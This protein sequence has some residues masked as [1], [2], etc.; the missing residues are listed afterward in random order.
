MGRRHVLPRVDL[1][2]VFAVAA[3]RFRA[4]PGERAGPPGDR[5]SAGNS[6]WEHEGQDYFA[7]EVE[8]CINGLAV[9][10]GSYFGEDVQGI[11][12]RLLGEQLGDGGWNCEAENGS[13]RSSF[14]T[15]IDVL[16]GLLEHERAVGESADVAA[17]RHR[18]D[19][20]LLERQLMRR[21][22]TGAV[23]EPNWSLFSFPTR[24]FYD[25][26]RGL[27]YLRS[28]GAEPDERC[29]E[30]IQLVEQKRVA[31]GRWLLE[32]PHPGE[33]HFDVDQGEGKPSRWIT[34][35]ASR[36]LDWYEK[37]RAA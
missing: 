24:Y 26:L 16:E 1:H 8:P 9:A 20:Y 22:S 33:V 18:A 35:R 11:V 2:D 19:E 36:V 13:M 28:A 4:R 29:A 5:S 10:I 27:D 14:N 31:D 30:A 6:K 21:L 37:R 23:I 25:V 12:D 17:A 32:N 34:L 15:T 7:G 3:A